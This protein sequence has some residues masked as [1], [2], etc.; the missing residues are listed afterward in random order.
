MVDRG[1]LGSVVFFLAVA[2]VTVVAVRPA[3]Q[4]EKKWAEL[5]PAG[6]KP[7]SERAVNGL[8]ISVSKAGA[9]LSITALACVVLIG[10][11]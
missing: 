5:V 4:G 7:T 1:I 3:P 9:S 8:A 11:F 10:F 6:G 2:A